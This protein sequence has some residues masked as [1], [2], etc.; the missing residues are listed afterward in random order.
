VFGV[1]L[2]ADGSVSFG[3]Q[4]FDKLPVD[5]ELSGIRS[6]NNRVR[7]FDVLY[8]IDAVKSARHHP[9]GVLWIRD[10]RHCVHPEPASILDIAPTIYD[11]IEVQQGRP[12]HGASLTPRF[13][14]SLTETRQAA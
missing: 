11:L 10:G 14:S 5:A 6:D 13:R 12:F 2:T 4:I 7:F 3:C 1:A 8:P 9:E